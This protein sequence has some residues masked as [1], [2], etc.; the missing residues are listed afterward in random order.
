[1]KNGDNVND[2]KLGLVGKF[3]HS[4]NEDGRVNWQG[5]I[6]Q[7]IGDNYYLIDT[8]ELITGIDYTTRLI[9]FEDMI[10]F[11]FYETNEDMNNTYEYKLKFIKPKEV[12]E[13]ENQAAIKILGAVLKVV[14]NN[15]TALIK[16][17]SDL[18]PHEHGL[19]KR[20]I[21]KY[22]SLAN[23]SLEK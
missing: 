19:K 3:F 5:R 18:F 16:L 6:K 9:K 14:S 15:Q 12:N 20:T 21:E 1:M 4:F 23:K 2:Y 10:N 11:Q 13:S 17:I 8:F 7:Y 22:F